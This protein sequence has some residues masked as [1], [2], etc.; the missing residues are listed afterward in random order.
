MC[1]AR[2]SGLCA[3][4][5]F[6]GVQ[7]VKHQ[8]VVYSLL[9]TSLIRFA[10]CETCKSKTNKNTRNRGRKEKANK[11]KKWKCYWLR[12][13]W[14]SSVMSSANHNIVIHKWT[15]VFLIQFLF[16][17]LLLLLLPSFRQL[18]R[19]SRS[20]CRLCIIAID[21]TSTF[22]RLWRTHMPT[23][24]LRSILSAVRHQSSRRH[25]SIRQWLLYVHGK[26]QSI[27]STRYNFSIH[28]TFPH[29]I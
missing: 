22:F 4:Y 3:L 25:K 6:I 19:C 20:N 28:S 7:V 8:L 12:L 21:S 29:E 16:G 14:L 11:N 13:L 23:S 24:M 26:L 27:G 10:A 18:H 15:E 5:K 1:L 17:S 2:T 9:F